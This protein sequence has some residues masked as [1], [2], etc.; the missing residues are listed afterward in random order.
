MESQRHNLESLPDANPQFTHEL[1]RNPSGSANV[2]V[3]SYC[4]VCHKYI[5]ASS[6]PGLLAAVERLHMCDLPRDDCS[7][8]RPAA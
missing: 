4:T 8:H 1:Q 2:L 3:T 7:E 5:A 6:N